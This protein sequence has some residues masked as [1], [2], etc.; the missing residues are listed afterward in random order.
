MGELIYTDK[1]CSDIGAI[2]RVPH[3]PGS[4][5]AAPYRGG[6]SRRL[7]DLVH[8]L[9][10]AIDGRDVNRLATIYDFAGM[11]TRQGYAVMARLDGIAG[12][13][14]VDVMPIYGG[15]SAVL[16]ETGRVIDPNTDGYYPQA[17]RRRAP[18]GLRVEQTFRNGITMSRTDF[19]LRKRLGCWWITL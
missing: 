2:E 11:S 12:R 19:G 17:A 1:R 3:V 7:T 8:Q 15:S 13:T 14:L 18:V 4:V 6:C 16:D 10:L 5:A 9:T